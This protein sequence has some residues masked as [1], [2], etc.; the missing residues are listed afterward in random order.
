MEPTGQTGRACPK[1]RSTRFRGDDGANLVEYALLIALIVLVCLGGI[2]LFAKKT[3]SKLDC[4]S[5]AI[6][7]EVGATC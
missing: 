2:S 3:T 4:A 7:S 6:R 1:V 5:S